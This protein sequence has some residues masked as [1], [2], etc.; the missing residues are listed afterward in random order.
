MLHVLAKLFASSSSSSSHVPAFN[1][2]GSSL[3]ASGDSPVWCSDGNEEFLAEHP[4]EQKSQEEK[5]EEKK[6]DF[7]LG[8]A[9]FS[10]LPE[11]LGNLQVM[12]CAVNCGV[13]TLP[14]VV[15][16]TGLPKLASKNHHCLSRG[17]HYLPPCQ[18]VAADPNHSSP[19]HVDVCCIEE[20]LPFCTTKIKSEL[21]LR[22]N[23]AIDKKRVG[24]GDVQFRWRHLS[25]TCNRNMLIL[26]FDLEFGNAWEGDLD[27]RATQ[28]CRALN[29]LQF[30]SAA[31]MGYLKDCFDGEANEQNSAV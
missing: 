24:E 23:E 5:E 20:V 18:Q 4:E 12:T 29:S 6:I 2:V 10:S 14:F 7:R 3:S 17:S 30:V 31:K 28:T 26:A 16:I 22:F 9:L 13:P 21:D 25:R 19:L 1:L 8:H 11:P 15:W 27:E